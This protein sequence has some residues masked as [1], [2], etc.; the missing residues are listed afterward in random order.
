M[1]GIVK[2]DDLGLY[3]SRLPQKAARRAWKQAL[4]RWLLQA[5]PVL[6]KSLSVLGTAAMFLVGGGILAHGLPFLQ[7]LTHLLDGTAATLAGLLLDA[8]TGVVAGA[9][10]Y[11]LLALYARLRSVVC[12][13]RAVALG[14]GYIS[15]CAAGCTGCTGRW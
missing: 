12:T 3:L 6:M 14:V 7:Q 5:A 2:L 13:G 10:V 4:G 1:A 11:V 8:V 9:L 15:Q